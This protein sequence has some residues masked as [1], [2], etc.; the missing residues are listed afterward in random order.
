MYHCF[1]ADLWTTL[2]KHDYHILPVVFGLPFFIPHHKL[3]C[4]DTQGYSGAYGCGVRSTV[5]LA[6]YLWSQ[7]AGRPG[8]T[9]WENSCSRVC[10]SLWPISHLESPTQA[11]AQTHESFKTLQ[12]LLKES[13]YDIVF[14]ASQLGTSIFSTCAILH[15][16]TDD[17][18]RGYIWLSFHESKTEW[19][20]F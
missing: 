15:Y 12:L 20:D 1:E 18:K 17:I 5:S 7:R 16:F 10:V 11:Q 19:Q 4:P 8:D 2:I 14:S 13:K 3:T 6:G 9:S